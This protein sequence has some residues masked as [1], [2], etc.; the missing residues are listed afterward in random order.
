[1]FVLFVMAYI[2][3]LAG[4]A[5]NVALNMSPSGDVVYG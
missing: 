2:P 4:R 1:M 3:T 5:R